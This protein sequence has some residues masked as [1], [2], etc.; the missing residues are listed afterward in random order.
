MSSSTGRGDL[1]V[2]PHCAQI[3]GLPLTQNGSLKVELV[4]VPG[5]DNPSRSRADYV[6][7]QRRDTV[8]FYITVAT[9]GISMVSVVST[10]AIAIATVKSLS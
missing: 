4:P 2:Q 8:R 3:D 9:L 10:A 6:T 1:P 7:E 5:G